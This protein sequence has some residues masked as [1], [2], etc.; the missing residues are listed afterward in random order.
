M[1]LAD[2][3]LPGTHAERL[4]SEVP[5]SREVVE[6]GICPVVVAGDRAVTGDMPF[7]IGAEEFLHWLVVAAGVEGAQAVIRPTVKTHVTR[8]L[9]K[10]R[11]RDRVQTVVLS[12]APGPGSG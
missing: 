1:L 10:L 5:S 2:E 8:L 12:P 11:L 9:A 4:A 3:H 7:D 6:D